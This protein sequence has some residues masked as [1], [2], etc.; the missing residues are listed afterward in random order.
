MT[1]RREPSPR[2]RGRLGAGGA[3][4]VPSLVVR[5][6]CLTPRAYQRIT[7]LALLA[8]VF[9][10]V[11]GAAVRLTGSGL[12]CSDW[13][14]CEDNQLVA[15]LEYHALIEFVNR[16]ITGVVSIAVILAVLGSRR[17]IPRRKDLT[18]W[19]LGL[20]AGVLAQIILGGITV[21]THLTPPIVMAHFLL[22]IV[23]VWNAV[24]LH[25]RAGHD[26]SEGV[27]VVA[28]RVRWLG[29]ALVAAA[30][31]V[32]VAGTVVTGTGPHGGDED[33]DR[34]SFDIT[35]VVRIHSISAWVFLVLAVWTLFELYRGGAPKGVDRRAAWL[36]GAIVVQGALGYVQYW[37]GVPPG[38]VLLHV[39]GS[40]LVWIAALRLDLGFVARPIEAPTG[41]TVP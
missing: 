23:L 29:R 31:V 35:E 18:W 9:I 10:I 22:S 34:L 33:V 3:A 19:S 6:P 39:F 11:T 4:P 17:R 16:L 7:L 5:L 28:S 32:L 15:P 13:P 2:A 37:K 21:R 38:L 14:T 12:G 25:E 8:L 1:S 40:V 24:V 27:P 20:V 36:V 26:G 41:Q 30:A